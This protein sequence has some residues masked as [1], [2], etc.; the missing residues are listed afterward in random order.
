MGFWSMRYAHGVRGH[1]SHA[2]LIYSMPAREQTVRNK[3][4]GESDMID[5]RDKLYFLM[6]RTSFE[7]VRTA[8]VQRSRVE[9]DRVLNEQIWMEDSGYEALEIS[10]GQLLTSD[11]REVI[12]AHGRA[13]ALKPEIHAQRLAEAMEQARKRD[14]A[15]AE[16]Q[17]QPAQ[18]RQPPAACT[19]LI[20]GQLCGGNLVLAAVCPRCALGKS[21]VAAT[22]TCDV[23]GHVTAIM[24]G[25]R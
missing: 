13:W 1:A 15:M 22:L 21:G 18:P 20:D 5:F 10:D 9:H 7:H 11:G 3:L 19:S 12:R 17:S 14:A 23:C 2:V 8:F 24:R 6:L 4:Q 25:G 16:P